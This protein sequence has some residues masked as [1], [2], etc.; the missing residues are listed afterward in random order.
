MKKQDKISAKK[1]EKSRI[2][3]LKNLK[4]EDIQYDEDNLPFSD[5]DIKTGKLKLIENNAKIDLVN[6]FWLK[7]FFPEEMDIHQ[8]VNTIIELYRD[9]YENT[10]KVINP[11]VS[12]KKKKEKV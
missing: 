9:F 10:Q 1:I 12:L 8:Q 11:K 3:K 2:E 5:K 7:D 6:Y 4:D